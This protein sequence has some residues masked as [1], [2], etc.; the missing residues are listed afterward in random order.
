VRRPDDSISVS[1]Q[2]AI[3]RL[4][5][6][7][8]QE[9]DAIG[10]FPTPVADVLAA[11][12]VVVSDEQVLDE[13]FLAGLRK[14]AG[15]ALRRALSKV[16]GV[17]DVAGRV[18]YLDRS[19]H[20]VKQTFLTLHEAAHAVLPWQRKMFVVAE[21]CQM[22]IAPEISEVF[23]REANAFASEVLFQIDQFSNEA[24]DH[25]FGIFVPV[26]LGKR[27]GASIYSS[28]R[29]YV[30]GNRRACAVLVLEPPEI[31]P[32]RGCV[33]K[34]RRVV[35]SPS[36]R[37]SIGPIDWPDE[38]TPDDSIG[39]LVPLGGRKWS[40]PREIVVID[41]RGTKHRCVAEA[42]TQQYQVFVLIHAVDVPMCEFAEL[43]SV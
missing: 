10:R 42:F 15:A 32:I 27:Y 31:C 16:L 29:R 30:S 41:Y 6:K 25:E 14:Q 5:E 3:R 35:D 20:A 13:S 34:F 21:D 18:I 7:A 23:E 28:V 43:L 38:F 39:S 36:F 12:N 40:R 1:Q 17:L 37:R 11:A 26:K 24:E 4:A 22:T 19:I 9:A 33:A 2:T 8:L